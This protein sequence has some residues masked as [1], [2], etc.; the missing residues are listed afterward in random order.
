VSEPAAETAG[1]ANSAVLRVRTG[2]LAAPLLT[3]VVA[4][5]LSRAECPVDRLDDAMVI[6]DALGA[7]AG[8]HAADGRVEFTVRMRPGAME[9]RVGALAAEGATRLSKATSLP[10]V[11][12]VLEPIADEIRVESSAGGKDDE[13]VLELGFARGRLDAEKMTRPDDTS[14]PVLQRLADQGSAD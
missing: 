9:L 13:L 8:E 14:G 1:S 3:R 10:G 5:M 7:H 2:P 4:M 6:C 11:G 12:D